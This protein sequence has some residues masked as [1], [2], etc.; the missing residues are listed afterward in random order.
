MSIDTF[1][2]IAGIFAGGVFTIIT[3]LVAPGLTV[4]MNR[5]M[6]LAYTRR[7]L[8]SVLD[9]CEEYIESWLHSTSRYDW[10]KGRRRIFG[11]C[12]DL[13]RIKESFPVI[14]GGKA[15]RSELVGEGHLIGSVQGILLMMQLNSQES[16]PTDGQ[17]Q[18]RAREFGIFANSCSQL[19]D[20][21][22]QVEGF[23]EFRLYLLHKV[24][25]IHRSLWSVLVPWIRKS[26]Q[27]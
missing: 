19:K 16:E 3:I 26:F 11:F 6:H 20:I 15:R 10:E 5:M 24:L 21:A 23:V 7:R 18:A 27:R 8:V 9:E 17:R 25:E 12:N 4:L 13:G 2:G 14:G 1:I 22:D